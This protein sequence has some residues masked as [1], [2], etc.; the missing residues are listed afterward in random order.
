LHA[1]VEN[2]LAEPVRWNWSDEELGALV[3]RTRLAE[4]IRMGD[5]R[6]WPAVRAQHIKLGRVFLE[7]EKKW[8]ERFPQTRTVG[9]ELAFECSWDMTAEGPQPGAASI[10]LSGRLDRVDVD[11]QGRYA[12]IDYKATKNNL[13]N[14]QSWLPNRQIQLALYA[15]LLEMGLMGLPRGPVASANYYVV[16]DSDRH[17]GFHVKDSTSELYSSEDKH[18]NFIDDTDKEELFKQ[19]R[20]NIHGA[21]ST[22]VAGNF[23]PAPLDPKNCPSC[24][25]RTLCRAPHLN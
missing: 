20:A 14:W 16:R 22:I 1:L 3:D 19:L 21:I 2:L 18:R 7:H 24:S 10:I 13:R 5:E 8:R 6:L 11:S 15:Q 23:N 9:R 4:E 12:L 17:F 25:W